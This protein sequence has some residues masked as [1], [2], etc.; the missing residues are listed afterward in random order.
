MSINPDFDLLDRLQATGTFDA[1]LG[2]SRHVVVGCSG[3]GDSLCLLDLLCQIAGE[4]DLRLTV[5]H[6]NHGVRGEQ[7]DLEAEHVAA[8]AASY[9]LPAAIEKAN[10]E[11]D[12]SDLEARCRAARLGFF[13]RTCA[14]LDADA[15]ALAHTLDDRVETVLLNLARGAGPRGLVGMRARSVVG[16]LTLVR[17]LLGVRRHELRQHLRGRG[18]A[19]HDDPMNFDARF[20][21]VRLRHEVLPLLAAAVPG[22]MENVARAAAI[23]QADEEWIDTF[24]ASRLEGM[25]LAESFPGGLR[26]DAAALRREHHGLQ[27]RLLRLAISRVRGDLLGIRREH[28]AAVIERVLTGEESAR[29]LP[30]IRVTL[31]DSA[32]RLLPLRDRILNTD[33][34]EELAR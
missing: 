10:I 31:V 13:Q 11:G 19:W 29:D 25:L 7:S 3:G 2:G 34:P 33:R 5:A 12:S 22:A 21:R 28:V 8:A 32:L 4:R 6:L 30:G 27:A 9:G 26:L 17:P 1:L 20:T 15:V 18:I 14:L 23:L 16:P 24:V